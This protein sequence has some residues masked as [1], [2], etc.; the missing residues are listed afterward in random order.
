MKA[1]SQKQRCL[2]LRFQLIFGTSPDQPVRRKQ[3]VVSFY[4]FYA[5][6]LLLNH[7]ISKTCLYLHVR[8]AARELKRL[9]TPFH[10]CCCAFY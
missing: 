6:N 1:N 9:K 2:A 7:M 8:D 10:F 4:N 3:S 5:F